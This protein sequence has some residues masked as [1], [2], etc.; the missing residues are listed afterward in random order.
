MKSE[1]DIGQKEKEHF[2]KCSVCHEW[3]DMRDLSNVFE[4][5]HWLK[6]KPVL[7]FS[8]V[9]MV[10]RENEVYIKV[11]EKMITMRRKN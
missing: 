9:K 2:S 11:G 1:K 6:E 3:F 4:H 7:P 10:G 5:E 8:H